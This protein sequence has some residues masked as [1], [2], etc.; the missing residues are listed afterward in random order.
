[1]NR[2]DW[3]GMMVYFAISL[4]FGVSFGLIA[5]IVHTKGGAHE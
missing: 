3:T 5:L 4:L 2:K 1:M